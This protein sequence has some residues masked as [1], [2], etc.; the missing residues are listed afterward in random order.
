LFL[1]FDF[2]VENLDLYAGKGLKLNLNSA[3]PEPDK[4]V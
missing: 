1:I 2:D 3:I 4:S